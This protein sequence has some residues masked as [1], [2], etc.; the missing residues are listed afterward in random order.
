MALE[1][2]LCSL[3]PFHITDL[4]PVSMHLQAHTCKRCTGEPGRVCTDLLRG[5]RGYFGRQACGE[6]A[7][8]AG[9]RMEPGAQVSEWGSSE[10]EDPP[11][12]PRPPSSGAVPKH[13]TPAEG[14]LRRVPSRQRGGPAEGSLLSASSSW[15]LPSPVR[16]RRL[17]TIWASEESSEQLGPEEDPWAPEE[18]PPAPAEVTRQ[19]RQRRQQR[20]KQGEAPGSWT[21]N[22]RL[23]GIPSTAGQRPRDPKKLAAVMERVRRWEAR[24][25]W[26]IEEAT[27]HELTVED[28]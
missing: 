1:C 8:A 5:R 2:Q 13:S 11:S 6:V 3:L 23:P 25:L 14:S 21:G 18:E 19:R 10:D 27:R 17:S 20:K 16:K 26:S 28:D 7:V 15:D 4:W 12:A 9:S 24:L 22:M